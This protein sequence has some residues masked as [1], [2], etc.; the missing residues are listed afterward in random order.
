VAIV[1]EKTGRFQRRFD[2]AGAPP[3][4]VYRAVGNIHEAVKEI[5]K[6]G[7]EFRE[8]PETQEKIRQWLMNKP[9]RH[10]DNL[11]A[12]VQQYLAQGVRNLNGLKQLM[13]LG[14][15]KS[16]QEVRDRCHAL[17]GSMEKVLTKRLAETNAPR[18]WNYVKVRASPVTVKQPGKTALPPD[19]TVAAV[20]DIL[21]SHFGSAWKAGIAQRTYHLWARN[22]EEVVEKTG[23]YPPMPEGAASWLAF[24]S[25]AD[26]ARLRSAIKGQ[27]WAQVDVNEGIDFSQVMN[28]RA[29]YRPRQ[30]ARMRM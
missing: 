8:F 28:S 21:R 23:M 24:M 26:D 22:A 9:L 1:N 4:E 25:R 10:G 3:D 13:P 11:D 17:A 27:H 2:I 6:Q 30:K 12:D 15:S 14:L 19:K 16:Q 29:T 20:K 5:G 7:I 18:A